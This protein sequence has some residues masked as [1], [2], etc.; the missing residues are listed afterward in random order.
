MAGKGNGGGGKIKPKAPNAQ[1]SKAKAVAAWRKR[2]I[3][4]GSSLTNA[5][6]ASARNAAVKLQYGGQQQ[7]LTQQTHN[8]DAWFPQYQ[9]EL[10]RLNNLQQQK[11]AAAVQQIATNA[12]QAQAQQSQS[13]Q[14]LAG[15]L[16]SDAAS[17]G[18][19]YSGQ[20]SQQSQQA[21]N[22]GQQLADAFGSAIAA[23]GTAYSGNTSGQQGVAA[24]AQLGARQQNAADR[25]TLKQNMGAAGQ[26]FMDDT[27]SN[28]QKTVLENAAFGLKKQTEADTNAAKK[29]ARVVSRKNKRDQI[30]S[31]NANTDKRITASQNAAAA[32]QQAAQQAARTKAAE[33]QQV[34]VQKVRDTSTKGFAKLHEIGSAYDHYS[35]GHVPV[36]KIVVD[37]NTGKQ[38][39]QAVLKNGKPVTRKPTDGEIVDSLRHDGYGMTEINLALKIKRGQPLSPHDVAAAHELGL[40]VPR[41]LIQTN[42]QRYNTSRT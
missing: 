25:R 7:A 34:H 13:N 20:P 36:T 35:T 29:A 15:Q 6:A 16:Q 42:N 32:K 28:E 26:K 1:A 37:P 12:A 40:R 2:P 39:T 19:T 14:A 10:T 27:R 33:K 11:Y 18:A 9:Q 41:N 21:S 8:I 31:T 24:A 22:L 5:Q 30:A 4:D 17:R 38:S 3:V 23:Q